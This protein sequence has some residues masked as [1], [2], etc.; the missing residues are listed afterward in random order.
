MCFLCLFAFEVV[1]SQEKTVTVTHIVYD[2]TGRTN[3]FFLNNILAPDENRKFTA[4]ELD[5]YLEELRQKLE[6][7]RIFS[8]INLTC[9]ISGNE[10]QITVSVKESRNTF[11]FPGPK[12]SSASGLSLKVIFR[13]N[14]LFGTMN[15]L[16]ADVA[17]LYDTQRGKH[18]FGPEFYLPFLLPLKNWDLTFNLGFAGEIFDVQDSNFDFFAEISAFRRFE[19]LQ[20][21]F[22]FHQGVVKDPNFRDKGNE[23]YLLEKAFVSIPVRMGL[24]PDLTPVNWAFSLS[25]EVLISLDDSR[26]PWEGLSSDLREFFSPVIAFSHDFSVKNVKWQEKFRHGFSLSV[27]QEF[28][29]NFHSALGSG[30][31]LQRFDLYT[32]VSASGFINFRWGALVLRGR[33]LGHTADDL[34]VRPGN[35]IRGIYDYQ[36]GRGKASLEC[37]QFLVFNLDFPIRLFRT[38]FKTWTENKFFRSLDFELQLVPFADFAFGKGDEIFWHQGIFTTGAEILFY[39]INWDFVQLR[40]SCAVNVGHF[41]DHLKDLPHNDA[42]YEIYFGTE[43]HF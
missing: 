34:F 13:E 7:T 6:D 20:V 43:L 22:G 10:A 25:G 30:T 23:T 37:A 39:P 9:K 28:S 33:F 8:E 15:S 16:S 2:I 19:N 26:L 17:Y 5:L 32:D 4:E 27:F 31:S 40:A 1:H 41:I 12:Y 24:L 38:D 35:Q 14:N 42:I 29:Y 11:V 18:G 36:R 21:G 3:E